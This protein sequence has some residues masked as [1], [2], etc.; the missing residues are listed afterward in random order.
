MSGCGRREWRPL[1]SR[2]FDSPHAGKFFSASD[3]LSTTALGRWQLHRL[4]HW[5]WS[6]YQ[7]VMI[8]KI[9]SVSAMLSL[10]RT[11]NH[12]PF[13]FDVPLLFKSL[14]VA[15][16]LYGGMPYAWIRWL[17]SVHGRGFH[18]A[19]LA[20][21]R[22]MGKTWHGGSHWVHNLRSCLLHDVVVLVVNEDSSELTCSTQCWLFFFPNVSG[23][24]LASL[25]TECP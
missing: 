15:H 10:M 18:P 3:Y 7:S 25:H 20:T 11:Y 8:H 22:Y 17:L 9:V 4:C 16:A 12:S 23:T 1:L 13:L 21:C 5:N 24:F 2:T 19:H 14:E 6:V